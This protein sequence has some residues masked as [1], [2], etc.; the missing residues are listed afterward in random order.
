MADRQAG[1]EGAGG[2]SRFGLAKILGLGNGL[3]LGKG[4]DFA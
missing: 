4:I 1:R 2:V 3:M